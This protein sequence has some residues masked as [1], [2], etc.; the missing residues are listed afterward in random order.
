[1]R[2]ISEIY[3]LIHKIAYESLVCLDSFVNA[4]WYSKPYGIKPHASKKEYLALAEIAKK[5]TS[6]KKKI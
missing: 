4:R 6:N 5:N 2:L 1:M 3:N